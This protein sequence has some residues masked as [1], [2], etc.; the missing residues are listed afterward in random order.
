MRYE[1]DLHYL[2]KRLGSFWG[3]TSD[4]PERGHHHDGA[5]EDW[6]ICLLSV[7]PSSFRLFVLPIVMKSGS[8]KKSPS[9]AKRR[10]FFYWADNLMENEF[11]A[12]PY[13]CGE[14][15]RRFTMNERIRAALRQEIS[16]LRVFK[17]LK[18]FSFI[19]ACIS[20]RDDMTEKSLPSFQE[21]PKSICV[22]PLY[23][24]DGDFLLSS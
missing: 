4:M 7:G 19:P 9:F 17:V 18:C 24:E 11:Q 2:I 21:S 6:R 23:Q 22:D 3:F 12:Y 13:Y 10:G 16:R 8:I 14:G 5:V 20:A 1:W 15:L